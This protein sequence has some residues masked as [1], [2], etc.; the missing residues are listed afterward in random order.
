MN[1]FKESEYY[2]S[3]EHK[4]NFKKCR[5]AGIEEI[6]KLKIIRI[7]DY[8]K[9]PNLCKN[10]NESLSYEKKKNKFCCNS[11]AA[12]YN[13]KN[14]SNDFITE[15]FREKQRK[16]AI[17]NFRNGK[18]R[19][20]NEN[21]KKDEDINENIEIIKLTYYDI[22]IKCTVCGNNLNIMQK[23]RKNKY[24][25]NTCRANDISQET[26]QKISLKAK[27][28]VKNG[29]HKGWQSRNIESYP[30]TFF[31]KVL[32]NNNIKYEFNK[33]ISKRSLGLDCDASYFLDFY[34]EDKNI[35]LEVDGKQHEWEERQESDEVRDNAL[36][37]NGFIVYRIKW[38]NINTKKGK[39]YIKN[40]IE[41]LIKY[42]GV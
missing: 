41:K 36:I 9:S 12:I 15:E 10:C 31:K 14:R 23:R 24:C 26:R 40:E 34:I 6:K 2:M 28:N 18:V 11:C 13:N 1:K 8:E 22:D 20:K 5:V 7:L 39:E 37:E 30:E 27:E 3:D 17:D 33:P 42:I 29:T 4:K 32:E 21:I 16:T 38:K 19:K 25:S 35:D